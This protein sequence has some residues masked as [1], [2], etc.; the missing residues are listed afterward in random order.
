MS[1]WSGG[2]VICPFYNREAKNSI[3]CTHNESDTQNAYDIWLR[4]PDSYTKFIYKRNYCSRYYYPNC[5]VAKMF[6]RKL[7]GSQ[8]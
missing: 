4:F 5:E 2:L 7:E 1:N 6:F 8:S 3:S